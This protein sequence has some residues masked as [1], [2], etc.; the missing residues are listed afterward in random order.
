[1]GPIIILDK[2]A[3]QS[4]SARE[5]IYLDIHFLQNLTPILCAEILG[6]LSKEQR[7]S[8]T[9]DDHVKGLAAKF[10]GSGPVTNID[11]RTLCIE[12]LLGNRIPMDGRIIPQSGSP[13]RGAD[14]SQ[15]YIIDLSPFNVA[16]LRWSRG[17]FAEFERELAQFWRDITTSLDFDSIEGQVK[18]HNVVLPRVSSFEDL[19]SQAEAL[20]NDPGLQE[21]WLRWL[22]GQLAISSDHVRVIWARWKAKRGN[23]LSRFSPY[24]WHCMRV[25]LMLLMGTHHGLLSWRSTNL[26][27]IQYLYYLPFCMVFASDDRLHQTLAPLILRPDQSFVKGIDLKTDLRRIADY[28]DALTERQQSLLAYALSSYPRPAKDS[29]VHKLWKKHMLLWRPGSGNRAI[30]LSPEEEAE[31]MKWVE[32]MFKE[33]EGEHYF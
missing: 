28:R 33:V 24:P 5:H 13:A 21:V 30:S 15:G 12:S 27:D 1:M 23:S 3:F 17:E 2:S 7:G 4:L 19:P 14:G 20:L 16:I 25:L 26:L 9:A 11:Y 8:K 31:A 6:D 22:I 18:A 29:V 10:G 32:G